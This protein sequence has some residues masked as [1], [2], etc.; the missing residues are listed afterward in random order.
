MHKPVKGI[1][2]LEIEKLHAAHVDG[3]NISEGG[4]VINDSNDAS[5]RFAEAAYAKNL[6]NGLDGL[7]NGNLKCNF[8]DRKELHR[9][10]SNLIAEN[11]PDYCNGD[12][13]CTQKFLCVILYSGLINTAITTCNLVCLVLLGSIIKSC[14]LE[15]TLVPLSSLK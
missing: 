5:G 9:N 13:S 12:V 3:D 7:R 8:S 14:I 6:G 15:E 10:G 4:S 1:L 2:R 11:H